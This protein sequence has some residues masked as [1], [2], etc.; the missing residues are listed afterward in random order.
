[1]VILNYISLSIG[2]A[3]ISIIAW[4]TVLTAIEFVTLEIK[5]FAQKAV[6]EDIYRYREIVRHHLGSYLLLGLE[7]MI[8]ADI[9]RTIAG[10]SMRDVATLGIIVAIRTILGY[11]LDREL[12]RKT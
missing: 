5:R 9:V 2:I 1:M 11:F 7:F 12:T 10:P 6:S 3:G 8:A 4:G